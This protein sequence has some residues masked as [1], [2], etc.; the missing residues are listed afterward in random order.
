MIVEAAS[1]GVVIV[2]LAVRSAPAA[3]VRDA[4]LGESD[5]HLNNEH[6]SGHQFVNFLLLKLKPYSHIVTEETERQQLISR[7]EFI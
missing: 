1:V 3:G 6:D 5:R 7:L 2:D 4:Q